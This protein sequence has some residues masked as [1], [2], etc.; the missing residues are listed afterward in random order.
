MLVEFVPSL[1][2]FWKDKFLENKSGA[3][4][5][6]E[7]DNFGAGADKD[8]KFL[9]GDILRSIVNGILAIDF[10]EKIQQILFKEME[11]TVVLKLL[12]RNIGKYGYT[13]E[14]C[15]SQQLE[16][17]VGKEQKG[18]TLI[19]AVSGGEY[20]VYRPWMVVKRKE[21]SEDGDP[22][23]STKPTSSLSE[24]VEVQVVDSPGG[25]NPNKHTVV[26]FK[27]KDLVDSAQLRGLLL[28]QTVSKLQSADSG[29]VDP[30]A[31]KRIQE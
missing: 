22:T 31:G 19:E 10:S 11:H 16:L 18:T 17:V 9:E 2:L 15:A 26:S 24:L 14:L 6:L 7:L 25:L 1:I 20:A 27:E 12:G 21:V 30:G 28:A 13:K 5:K 3:F 8:L 29:S 23:L 4:D